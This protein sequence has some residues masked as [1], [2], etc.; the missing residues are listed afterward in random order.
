MSA[1]VTVSVGHE[2][3]CTYQ[4]VDQNGNPMVTQPPLDKPA[5]WTDTPQPSGSTSN[6]V[7]ADGTTDVVTALAA[8]QDTA[9]VS[10]MIGGKTFSDS[11]LVSVTPAPQV[12]TDVQIITQVQ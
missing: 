9:G 11:C 4:V 12:A 1:P 8:G 10:V 3:I 6:A 2:V 7:S 5:T